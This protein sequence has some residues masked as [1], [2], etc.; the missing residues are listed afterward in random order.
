M[1][2]ANR[3]SF[4]SSL[5]ICRLFISIFCFIALVE[6]SSTKLHRRSKNRYSC[7]LPYQIRSKWKTKA[8][9]FM[10][11]AIGLLVDAL[12]QVEEVPSIPFCVSFYHE[13]ILKFVKCPVLM[14]MITWLFFFLPVNMVDDYTDWFSNFEIS[15]HSWN[16]PYFVMLSSPFCIL[17]DSIC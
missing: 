5:P 10:I 4:I 16:K 3:S 12:C 14:D 7:F 6:T 2:S 15:L 1:S 9:S 13:W 17:P 8:F 11:L